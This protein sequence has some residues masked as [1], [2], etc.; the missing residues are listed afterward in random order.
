MK[1]VRQG[2]ITFL[3]SVFDG[4]T[5]TQA[6]ELF[7]KKD[8]RIIKAAYLQVNPDKEKKAKEPDP[9]VEPEK[10]KK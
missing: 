4:I 5:L 10:E 1:Q 2:G 7:P 3:A 9:V 8:K 6:Y